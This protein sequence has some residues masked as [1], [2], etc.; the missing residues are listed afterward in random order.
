MNEKFKNLKGSFSSGSSKNFSVYGSKNNLINE[1]AEAIKI[2]K[3]LHKKR[4]ENINKFLDNKKQK[5][6]S[7]NIEIEQPL[8][9]NIT[10]EELKKRIEYSKQKNK[11]VINNGLNESSDLTETLESIVK[12]LFS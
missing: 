5:E 8:F 11:E 4:L 7:K 3:E 2:A 9:E 10:D 1:K 6:E 12:D